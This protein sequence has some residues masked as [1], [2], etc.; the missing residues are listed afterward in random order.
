MEYGALVRKKL[1]TKNFLVLSLFLFWSPFF[2]LI[3]GLLIS[4]QM[5]EK[6]ETRSLFACSALCA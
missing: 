4:C 6:K 5:P 2:R 3:Q 1:E